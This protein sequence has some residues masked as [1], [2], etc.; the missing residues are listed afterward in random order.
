MVF[1]QKRHTF[2]I[3]RFPPKTQRRP[4]S[5]QVGQRRR[6]ACGILLEG[7]DCPMP[8][9]ALFVSSSKRG[10]EKCAGQ[11]NNNLGFSS[12]LFF[13]P[14]SFRPTTNAG[15]HV[16]SP[17]LLPS[18]SFTPFH[19]RLEREKKE[20]VGGR[21]PSGVCKLLLF[22]PSPLPILQNC[23]RRQKERLSPILKQEAFSSPI[24]TSAGNV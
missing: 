15:A 8:T 5:L 2:V 19:S 6:R 4:N 23:P 7:A 22:S 11:A 24:L 10:E 21:R 16:A 3:D 9:I 17:L 12:F 20:S 1:V 14:T 18:F 13:R